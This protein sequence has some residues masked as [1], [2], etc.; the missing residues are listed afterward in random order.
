MT[1]KKGPGLLVVGGQAVSGGRGDHGAV[2]LPSSY[3]NQLEAVLDFRFVGERGTD[4]WGEPGVHDL[5]HYGQA[6]HC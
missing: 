1:I 2:G 6:L 4:T 3:S 5:C